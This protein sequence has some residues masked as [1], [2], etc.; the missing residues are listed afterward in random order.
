MGKA[1]SSSSS[2]L[3]V[4]GEDIRSRGGRVTAPRMQVLSLLRGAPA[5]LSHQEIEAALAR[6]GRSVDR[7]TIY[8]VLDWLSAVGLAHR[9]TDAQG[10]FRFSAASADAP[11]R[12]HM[13]FRCT[14]CGGV[15]CLDVPPPPPPR[16]PRGFRLAAA[17]F[18]VRG[19]CP[20]CVKG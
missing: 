4:P 19:Q 17:E 9:A 3:A 7:V 18:D 20:A 14:G 12:S 13:H 16:L 8:R 6:Q 1:A 2:T 5:A 10:T 15:F 11:H